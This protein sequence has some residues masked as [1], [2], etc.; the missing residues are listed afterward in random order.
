MAAVKMGKCKSGLGGSLQ[1]SF[2]LWYEE[3]FGMDVEDGFSL[4]C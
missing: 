3:R 1:K 2:R 4:G